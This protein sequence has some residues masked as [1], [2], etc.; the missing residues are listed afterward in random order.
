MPTLPTTPS[1]L[2]PPAG[3]DPATEE[4]PLN[5]SVVVTDAVG[6]LA[7]NRQHQQGIDRDEALR[8]RINT[9]TAYLLAV[10]GAVLWVDGSRPMSGILGMADNR[11]TGLG[12]PS[13]DAD[14]TTKLYVD[15]ADA[16]LLPRNGARAMTGALQMG[17]NPIKGVANP[18]DAGD[19]ATKTYTDA[20]D[21]TLLDLGT[22]RALTNA[23]QPFVVSGKRIANVGAPSQ[24]SDAATK[25]Y[26]DAG[27]A[28]RLALT[29]GT[30]SG[31][32]GMG[33]NVISGLAAPSSGD[34]A[35]NRTYVDTSDALRLARDGSAP[36]TADTP[37]GSRKI[38]VLG[39]GTADSDA[40]N[41]GQ[42]R[43][44]SIGRA[45][46]VG[47]VA[48]TRAADINNDN[49]P[50][51]HGCLFSLDLDTRCDKYLLDVSVG[52]V[53]FLSGSDAR[54]PTLSSRMLLSLTYSGST[55][56]GATM[57]GATLQR[58]VLSTGS[59]PDIAPTPI[60]FTF[61]PV[62]TYTDVAFAELPTEDSGANAIGMRASYDGSNRLTLL[63]WVARNVSNLGTTSASFVRAWTHAIVQYTGL[64]R[65]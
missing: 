17:G 37:W 22:T 52:T 7:T 24:V 1:T 40:V 59:V 63:F 41:L 39:D 26:A 27:D 31:T 11:I 5:S 42:T 36:P 47:C 4:Y 2:N 61:N 54:N 6:P 10:S 13:S 12:A 16:S 46:H 55:I 57:V 34:H 8:A 3:F 64:S 21:A 29:G 30:M 45:I 15:T 14:A 35:T 18:T 19:A 65:R 49:T 33:N 62:G 48:A 58:D 9:S 60:N 25:G 56:T 28:L 20:Q 23:A 53:I 32:I 50:S 51:R 44:L 38:T 43:T